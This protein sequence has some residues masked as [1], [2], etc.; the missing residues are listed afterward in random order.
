[1][2]SVNTKLIGKILSIIGLLI[3]LTIIVYSAFLVHPLLEI[4][5]VG[6][7]LLIFGGILIP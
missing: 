3:A 4:F 1:M 7:L 6:I 5:I 2:K